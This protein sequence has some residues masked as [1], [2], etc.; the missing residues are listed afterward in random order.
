MTALAYI[1]FS[2]M[3]DRILLSML[4]VL[5]SVYSLYIEIRKEHDSSYRAACDFSENMSCS[6]VLTSK[7]ARGFGVMAKYLGKDH[8]LNA[9]NCNLGIIFYIVHIVVAVF[10]APP[11]CAPILLMMSTSSIFVSLY[12]GS[13]LAFVLRDFCLVCVT[14]Y[15]INGLLFYL[16]YSFYFLQVL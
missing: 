2:N 7:Y 12:L 15:V 13:I 1:L 8:L 5:I 4:G 16:N 9:R 10:F 14:T 6:K 11:L 3:T